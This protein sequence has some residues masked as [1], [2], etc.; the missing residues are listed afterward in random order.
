MSETSRKFLRIFW[1]SSPVVW[2]LPWL[3]WFHLYS[4][5]VRTLM[6][7]WLGPRHSSR[8]PPEISGKF[9]SSCR[10]VWLTES[11]RCSWVGLGDTLSNSLLV[12]SKSWELLRSCDRLVFFSAKKLLI[13]LHRCRPTRIVD[14]DA[15][16]KCMTSWYI[17]SWYL[18]N[19]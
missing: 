16:Y 14:I 2:R 19:M 13:Y 8:M 17:E 10:W 1:E 9:Q 12:I 15:E 4:C 5:Q 11:A 3:V 18:N 6:S 7:F